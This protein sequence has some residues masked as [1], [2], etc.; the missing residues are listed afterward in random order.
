MSHGKAHCATILK[1]RSPKPLQE[2]S[3]SN[4]AL[5][6]GFFLTFLLYFV[7][8]ALFLLVLYRYLST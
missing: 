3:S 7:L 4:Q 2:V 8:T 5:L 1:K 6:C